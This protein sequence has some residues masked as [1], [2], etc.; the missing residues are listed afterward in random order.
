MKK[1]VPTILLILHYIPLIWMFINE[2]YLFSENF[3]FAYED[4]KFPIHLPFVVCFVAVAFPM[5]VFLI[6]KIIQKN[7]KEN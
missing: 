4:I 6:I 7:S 2:K 3:F 5:D 1:V